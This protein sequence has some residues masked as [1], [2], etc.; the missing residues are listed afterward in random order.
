MFEGDIKNDIDSQSTQEVGQ[1]FRSSVRVIDPILLIFTSGTT[2]Y[3]IL[4]IQ[5]F[6]FLQKKNLVY[7]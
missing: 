4:D 3:N 7:F 6:G 5:L 1:N 2:G